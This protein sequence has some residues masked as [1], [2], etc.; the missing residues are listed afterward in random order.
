MS[1]RV[2]LSSLLYK[3]ANCQE[4]VEVGESS[5]VECLRSVEA[6][7]PGVR[8]WLYNKEGELSPVIQFFVNGE[9][10]YAD[11]LANQLKDGDEFFILFAIAGG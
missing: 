2:R 8:Q 9:R 10:V 1:V 7:C 6:Q 11:E 4:V 5:L 3:F